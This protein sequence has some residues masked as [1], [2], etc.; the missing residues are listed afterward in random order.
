MRGSWKLILTPDSGEE[1]LFDLTADPGEVHDMSPRRARLRD[2]LRAALEAQV[3]RNAE[4]GRGHEPVRRAGLVA[5]GDP[6]A[7]R[8]AQ[9][10]LRAFQVWR[11]VGVHVL[12]RGHRRLVGAV[13]LNIR[14]LV[15]Q[16]GADVH[17]R[18][19]LRVLAVGP[20]LREQRRGHKGE[21]EK[22]GGAGF[23]FR[24]QSGSPHGY[25]VEAASFARFWWGDKGCVMGLVRGGGRGS[26]RV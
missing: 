20:A 18:L 6:G 23:G 2:E 12:H 25:A 4:L 26:Q 10:L 11:Q 17:F 8:R 22:Q 5:V 16:P 13:Q 21:G 1:R 15:V 24:H 7:L 3:S 9:G 19:R 14:G